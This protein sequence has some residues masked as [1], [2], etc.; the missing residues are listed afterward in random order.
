MLERFHVP[1]DKAVFI[2]P[3]EISKVI[4]QIFIK[5]GMSPDHANN[6]SDVLT[7]ADKRGIDSHGA[8]NML[9]MYVDGFNKSKNKISTGSMNINPQWK[10]VKDYGAVAKIDGDGGLGCAIAP[11]GMKEAI[12]RAKEFGV[13][14]VTIMN[15]GHFGAAAYYANMAVEENMLGLATTGGGVGVVPT[16]SSEKLV[17]LN[18]LA[19]GAPTRKN[20]PFIFD[21][22]MS[23]VA[24]NKIELARRLGVDV[25]PGWVS[26]KDGVP[27]MKETKIPEYENP[28][29]KPMILPLGGT[30]EIGSHKGYG[31]SLILEILCGGLGNNGLGPFRRKQTTHH[32]T[33]Y[34]IDAFGTLEEFMDDVDQY[35]DKLKNS[36]PAPG[37][38]RVMYAGL[39]EHEEEKERNDNG[40]PYHPEVIDWFRSITSELQID[41]EY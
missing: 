24:G 23:S 35:L 41:F 38:D 14:S 16:F 1:T 20:P 30:R 12:K 21:A 37:F 15:S 2:K 7:Y 34:N 26:D 31:L 28:Q 25:M 32:F 18:P 40:I 8:S 13:G 22:S 39:P 10:V 9:R 19:V 5:L 4:Y 27:L 29:D 11:Y 33:V 6:V 3:K 36:N 17:G